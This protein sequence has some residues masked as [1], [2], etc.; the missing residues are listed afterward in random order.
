LGKSSGDHLP[1]VLGY[2]HQSVDGAD[3]SAVAAVLEADYLTTGPRVEQF[4][5]MLC[6]MTGAE[7]CIACAN[8]T[9]AL[10]LACMALGVGKGDIGLTSPISFLASANCIEYCGARADF[11]DIDPGTLCLSSQQLEA[12]CQAHKPPKV[13]IPVD[14]AGLGADLAAMAELS[15]TYGFLLIEDAAHALGSF[16]QADGKQY[17]CGSCGHTDLA[18]FS[19]HPVKTITTG[20]GGAV[21]TNNRSL[22]DRVRCLRNH[23]MRRNDALGEQHGDWAYEMTHLG[24]NYRITD[25]QCALGISQF[26]RLDEFRTR[27]R[28]IVAEYNDAFSKHEGLVLPHQNLEFTACPHLYPIR[29]KAGPTKRR[30]VYERLKTENIFCQVHYIPIYLQPYY[31]D[32]YSYEKGR[33]PQAEHYYSQTLSL[34]LFPAMSDHDVLRV[35]EQFF[36]ALD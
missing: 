28:Q 17:A 12:Y 6:E 35:I 16:Y 4:E 14:F 15:Q 24:F 19:F 5:T 31:A 30:Q 13:V 22:A 27:R 11:V 1:K 8:G 26:S 9:A 10:H 32:K 21:M 33:C 2:A 25:I 23:G 29:L 18:V 36:I 20:E 7:H 3:I 34:P